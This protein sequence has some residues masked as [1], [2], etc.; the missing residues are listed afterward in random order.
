MIITWMMMRGEKLGS[1]WTPGEFLLIKNVAIG[2]QEWSGSSSS[3]AG[4]PNQFQLC[5]RCLNKFP[6]PLNQL[7]FYPQ[8]FDA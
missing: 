2:Q 3:N 8:L 1:H 4:E 6:T 7:S 5:R